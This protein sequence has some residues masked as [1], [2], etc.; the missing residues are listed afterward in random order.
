MDVLPVKR[1]AT[2]APYRLTSWVISLEGVNRPFVDNQDVSFGVDWVCSP[3]TSCWHLLMNDMRS[4]CFE[5]CTTT[6][7][8]KKKKKQAPLANLVDL[9]MVTLA[10]RILLLA[11]ALSTSFCRS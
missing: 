6:E 9:S 11:L 5:D 1:P 2:R 7:R 8:K 4:T 10:P 3:P